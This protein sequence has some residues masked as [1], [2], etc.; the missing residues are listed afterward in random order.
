MGPRSSFNVSDWLDRSGYVTLFA[1]I[2]GAV[3]AAGVVLLVVFL[4]DGGD[5]GSLKVND[6]ETN[7]ARIT[8]SATQV[9]NTATTRNTDIAYYLSNNGGAQWHRVGTERRFQRDNRTPSP[10][11]HGLE[12]STRRW[13]SFLVFYTRHLLGQY[14]F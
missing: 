7:I 9:A 13:R 4:R 11:R 2:G 6:T 12:S 14:A 3:I 10:R 1:F 8:L 5:D